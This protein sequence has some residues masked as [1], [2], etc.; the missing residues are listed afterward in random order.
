MPDFNKTNQITVNL[1]ANDVVRGVKESSKKG[2][3]TMI[4]DE[5]FEID[6]D[7]TKF[8][9]FN[10]YISKGSDYESDCSNTLVGWYHNYDTLE[11]GCYLAEKV[12]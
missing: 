11:R 3:W 6:F 8:F 12:D 2:T 9:S 1:E 7:N 10:K 5:G 4:Y